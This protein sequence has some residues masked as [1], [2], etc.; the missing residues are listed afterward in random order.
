MTSEPNV[1]TS[2]RAPSQAAGRTSEFGAGKAIAILVL[3]FLA[4][5]VIGVVVVVASLIIAA[6][7]GANLSDPHVVR[8]LTSQ[9]SVPLLLISPLIA[10]AVIA[11]LVRLW[12]WDVVRDSS[13]AGIGWRGVPRR[14]VL[15][16]AAAGAAIVVSYLVVAK[17][18]LPPR[19]GTL[20]GPLTTIAAAG[21]IGRAAWAVVAVLLAPPI[22]EFL[23]RGL[24]LKGLSTSWGRGV[25]YVL[26]TICFVVSHL[27][28]TYHYL[29]ALIGI[30]LLAMATLIARV[31][32]A[33]IVP[34]ISV[35]STYNLILVL[36]A[37]TRWPTA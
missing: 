9:L 24:L 13:P 19:S 31:K 28:E 11:L 4:Q 18:L 8:L 1:A 25:A 36:W 10:T 12:A 16:W 21:G 32:S 7:T 30:T 15:Q 23:F 37:Y 35:H 6:V 14:D 3:V 34:A 17:F 20:P 5:L 27:F 33:S 26:V 29:P 2:E 22:E